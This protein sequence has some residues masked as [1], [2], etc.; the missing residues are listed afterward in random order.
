LFKR[1]ESVLVAVHTVGGEALL[2][3][4]TDLPDFWQ[5]VTGA[6]KWD[7]TPID[8][9]VRELR[10]ETGI[11]ATAA[12]Q[13][14]DWQRSFEFPILPQFRHRYAPDVTVNLEHVFSLQLP[15]RVPVRLDRKEHTEHVWLPLSEAAKRVWSWTNRAVLED[16]F[17]GSQIRST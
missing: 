3:K 1:P 5:S 6:L 17:G 2:L 11:E 13:L 9:A 12:T 15:G 8:A 7:E 4:R 16:L 14:H 10:E